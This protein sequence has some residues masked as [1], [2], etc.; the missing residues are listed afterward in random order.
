MFNLNKKN[1]MIK[2]LIIGFIGL[3][4]F[5]IGNKTISFEN[6][7]KEQAIVYTVKNALDYVHFA[8]QLVNDEFSVRFFE[9]YLNNL[10][11]TKRFLTQNEI[12]Q[13]EIY[14]TKLDDQILGKDLTFFNLSDKLTEE[15]INRVRSFYKT[16]LEKPYS[17]TSDETIEMDPDKRPW[18]KDEKELT[19]L[20]RKLF[21]YEI[22][23][24]VHSE[25]ENQKMNTKTDSI[26][27]SIN[28]IEK[29]ARERV[30]K[31]YDD[32]FDRL[33]KV[34]REDRFENY[35]NTFSNLFDPHTEYFSAKEKEDFDIKMQ[36]KLEGIGARLQTDKEYTKIV[37]I[38]PGGPAWKDKE[39]KTNDLILKV[40]QGNSDEYIDLTGMRIDDVV[41]HIRG[42][43]GTKVKLEVKKPDGSIKILQLTRD[44]VIIDE[45]KAKSVIV[46]GKG[47]N[48]DVGFIR[49]PSF[50]SEFKSDGNNCADDIKTEI[51]KLK[52]K[53]VKGII[54]DLR[55]NGG[56]SLPDVIKI[57]GYFIEKGPVVQVKQTNE[58]PYVHNDTDSEILYDGPLVILVNEM[59]ASASEILAAAVQ[60]YNRGV[61][62][63]S[64]AT[65]GK[66]TVQRFFDLD[67]MI[68]GSGNIKPLGNIKITTQKFYRING[69]STQLKGVESDIEL[70]DS[71]MYMEVGE[72]EFD[73]ALP[74]DKIQ[75]LSYSQNVWNIS[76][77]QEIINRSKL[78]ISSD[79]LLLKVEENARKL[80][81]YSDKTI[82]SLNLN[83]FSE[84]TKKRKDLDEYFKKYLDKELP[85]IM[86]KN[87]EADLADIQMDSSRIARND[88]WLKS[89]RKDYQI[90]EA[91]DVIKDL[92][93]LK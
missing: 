39:L 26:K 3:V 54:L 17:F 88:E 27:K 75:P 84:D 70:P 80:K 51:E 29:E 15:A 14:R 48:Q 38:I 34:N 49:L 35:I 64:K 69:G 86:V 90:K 5:L 9:E 61:V 44:E 47:N 36:G 66:G 21:K 32:M 2:G 11:G 52:A 60:D 16:L 59:S 57:A 82:V 20:W 67:N 1:I 72:R 77:K 65:F 50:Y 79:S 31:I 91:I 53:N 30:L 43:K 6:P 18:A 10:D 56:G 62:I 63:G 40:A 68:S 8:P 4:A 13:L 87:L 46:S 33:K 71:Y 45:T 58:K 92:N 41:T 76:S 12:S 73:N 74:W 19:D 28:Q 37:E 24:R 22:L 25:L 7:E 78:R 23:T 89:I 83:K 93:E 42:K 55:Y 85:S 81:E